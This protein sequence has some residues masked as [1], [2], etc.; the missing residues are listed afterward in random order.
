MMAK[1]SPVAEDI[2]KTKPELKP[3]WELLRAAAKRSM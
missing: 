1:V 3:M 2:V